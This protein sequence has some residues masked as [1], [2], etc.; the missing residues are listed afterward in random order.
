M[1][2]AHLPPINLAWVENGRATAGDG[3]PWIACIAPVGESGALY[4]T[5]IVDDSLL[6]IT[7]DLIE[8][9]GAPVRRVHRASCKVP[10]DGDAFG[11]PTQRLLKAADDAAWIVLN[12]RSRDRPLPGTGV[13]AIDDAAM[14]P[15][16][17]AHQQGTTAASQFDQ[18]IHG[19]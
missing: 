19:L 15:S 12:G 1:S 18:P 3:A 16:V 13:G 5:Q 9:R 4:R 14:K 10:L 7:V 17:T 2:T 8:R 6:T 11:E